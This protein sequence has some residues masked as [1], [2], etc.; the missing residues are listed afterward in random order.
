MLGCETARPRKE[1]DRWLQIS[2]ADFRRIPGAL[3]PSLKIKR[4]EVKIPQFQRPF[5]WNEDQA[6]RLLDSIASHYPVGSLLLWKTPSKLT[7]ERN[8]GDFY[9]PETDDLT[10]TDYVLDG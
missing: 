7:T 1:D 3:A 4:G 2:I 10:P 6:L 9:L 8:I 5:V